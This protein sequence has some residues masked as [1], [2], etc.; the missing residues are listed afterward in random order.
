MMTLDSHFEH[1]FMKK[2]P[3]LEGVGFDK[4]LYSWILGLVTYMNPRGLD[5]IRRQIH[6]PLGLTY[7]RIQR[8]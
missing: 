2:G 8:D 1:L 7:S 5:L 6:K 4:V 3:R